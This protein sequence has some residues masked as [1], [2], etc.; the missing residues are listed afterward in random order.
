ML[1]VN[2]KIDMVS[3]V[4]LVQ[5]CVNPEIDIGWDNNAWLYINTGIVYL[6]VDK[7]PFLRRGWAA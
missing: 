5:G 7:V 1:S 6:L 2:P 4:G 3:S